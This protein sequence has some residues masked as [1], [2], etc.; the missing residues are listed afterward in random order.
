LIDESEAF[1]LKDAESLKGEI[2]VELDNEV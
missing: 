2:V 1:S